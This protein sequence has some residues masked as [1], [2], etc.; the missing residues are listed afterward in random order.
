MHRRLLL[1]KILMM[2][3]RFNYLG[4]SIKKYVRHAIMVATI[5][6]PVMGMTAN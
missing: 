2:I 1:M 4:G 6:T 3:Y 5:V